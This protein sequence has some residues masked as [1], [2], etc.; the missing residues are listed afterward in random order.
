MKHFICSETD[1][2]VWLRHQV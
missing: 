2:M 1:S